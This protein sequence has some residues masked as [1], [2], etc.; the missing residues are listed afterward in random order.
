MTDQ[1]ARGRSL[2]VALF[3]SAVGGRVSRRRRAGGSRAHGG[4][5]PGRDLT[6]R[7]VHGQQPPGEY[8]EGAAV[9][10][11][12]QDLGGAGG[13]GS[14]G[15]LG[16]GPRRRRGCPSARRA[17]LAGGRPHGDRRS[18]G[19]PAPRRPPADPRPPARARA[20]RDPAGRSATAT[21]RTSAGWS[22]STASGS[23]RSRSASWLSASR[24]GPSAP[25]ASRARAS[26]A[27]I[28]SRS[29]PRPTAMSSAARRSRPALSRSPA[30]LR[31]AGG[32]QQQLQLPLGASRA[33]R[34]VDGVRRRPPG[35]RPPPE[36]VQ[37]LGQQGVQRAARC[38]RPAFREPDERRLGEALGQQ[39]LH[40]AGGD[41]LPVLLV[42]ARHDVVGGPAAELGGEQARGPG[43]HVLL[44]PDQEPLDARQPPLLHRPRVLVEPQ[45][46]VDLL[47]ACL[48]TVPRGVVLRPRAVRR[49]ASRRCG[50]CPAGRSMMARTSPRCRTAS[51]RPV[52][53]GRGGTARRRGGGPRRGCPRAARTARRGR[54]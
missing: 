35:L 26:S 38:P 8:V 45:P 20:P 9:A 21:A 47:G 18:R 52:P 49:C 48:Q 22:A 23:R 32:Q 30:V 34:G 3:R 43:G 13:A 15:R 41:P 51:G 14:R 24:S 54:P 16:P 4:G 25:A 10:G 46:V 53:P 12:A 33:L 1:A 2:R 42:G 29:C 19:F 28:A 44:R 17:A 50:R 27:P 6:A 40:L 7:V 11:Q 31:E 36:P 37:R 5:H 39:I